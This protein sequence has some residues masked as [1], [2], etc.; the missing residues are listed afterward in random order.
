MAFR[1]PTLNLLCNIWTNTGIPPIPVARAANV[2]CQL[3]PDRTILFTTGFAVRSIMQVLKVAA[4]TDI[5]GTQQSTGTDLI[6]L[7][8][9]SACYYT[10]WAVGDMARGFPNEYRYGLITFAAG[11]T[12]LP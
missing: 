1:L 8:A 7:P 11:P 5:R 3:A 2:P 6:E 9:G 12:P 10:V 4:G